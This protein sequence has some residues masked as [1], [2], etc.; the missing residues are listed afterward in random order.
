MS[1][2]RY[3]N[4]SHPLT[5]PPT[6]LT[7]VLLASIPIPLI[8]QNRKASNLVSTFL[9]G[10]ISCQN[11]LPLPVSIDS[12]TINNNSNRSINYRHFRN[13]NFDYPR[14]FLPQFHQ[15]HNLKHPNQEKGI[16]FII[17]NNE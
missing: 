2:K 17:I 13:T 7:L 4:C 16:N 6:P 9:F 1:F 8:L 10:L 3:T 5:P 15:T 12:M 14:T 11:T